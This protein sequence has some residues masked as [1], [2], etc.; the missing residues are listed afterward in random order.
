VT[1]RNGN[2]DLQGCSDE[3]VFAQLGALGKL[4]RG[5][6]QEQEEEGSDEQRLPRSAAAG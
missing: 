4:P 5:E 6:E 2:I 1:C 3:Q